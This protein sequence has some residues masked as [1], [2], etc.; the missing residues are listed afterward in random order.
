MKKE[1]RLI[2]RAAGIFAALAVFFTMSYIVTR[3]GMDYDA[4]YDKFG[5]GEA[6]TDLGLDRVGFIIPFFTA[7]GFYFWVWPNVARRLKLIN[8]YEQMADAE[9]VPV[10][11]EE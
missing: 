1:E 9:E 4:G 6:E 10:E 3:T 5:S 7:A 8:R 11:E 2:Y